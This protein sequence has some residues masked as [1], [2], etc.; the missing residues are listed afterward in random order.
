MKT[1]VQDT[2]KLLKPVKY[3]QRLCDLFHCRD[4]FGEIRSASLSSLDQRKSFI[5]DL[6]RSHPNNTIMVRWNIEEKQWYKI[7]ARRI[8]TWSLASEKLECNIKVEYIAGAS[9]AQR[10]TLY[11]DKKIPLDKKV[12]HGQFKTHKTGSLIITIDNREGRAPR[13]I[14]YQYK[15]IWYL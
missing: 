5:E 10:Y 12:L 8:V 11:S 3:L 6:K 14:W 7:G 4:T 9:H 1:T 15:T 2:I 13:T